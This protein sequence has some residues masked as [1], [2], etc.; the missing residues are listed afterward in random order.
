MKTSTTSELTTDERFFFEAGFDRNAAR[1][2]AQAEAYGQSHGWRVRWEYEEGWSGCANDYPTCAQLG[3]PHTHEVLCAVLCDAQG[4]VLESLGMII[5][6]DRAYG[7]VIEAELMSEAL[8]RVE[9][10]EAAEE[11]VRRFFAL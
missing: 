6:P 9:E 2:L 7:R 5:D 3:T 1:G 4:A 10:E 8:G 11:M